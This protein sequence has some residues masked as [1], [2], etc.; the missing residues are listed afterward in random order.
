MQ[1]PTERLLILEIL[2]DELMKD[3]PLENVVSQC[4]TAV[5][6]E[7]AKDPISRIN[8]VLMAL[9]FED[10]NKEFKE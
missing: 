6:I 10:P 4:M 7:D 1:L 3:V 8:Q 2:V 5:G 9:H